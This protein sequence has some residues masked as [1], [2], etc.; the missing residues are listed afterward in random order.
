MQQILLKLHRITSYNV[1]YTKLLR[2]V[3]P[4]NKDKFELTLKEFNQPFMYLGATGGDRLTI[5]DTVNV[6][7]ERIAELYY[8]TISKIMKRE[9]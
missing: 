9:E 6:G 3:Y 4:R 8:N 5:N 2:S 7:L 1:C